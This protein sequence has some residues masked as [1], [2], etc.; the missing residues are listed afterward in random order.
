VTN[1][2]NDL[3][4][5]TRGELHERKMWQWGGKL[6]E[7]FGGK[8]KGAGKASQEEKKHV[9]MNEGGAE[10]QRGKTLFFPL[11]REPFAAYF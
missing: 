2:K 1:R 5:N 4:T 10:V 3:N 11:C 7:K 6:R 9:I 8:R